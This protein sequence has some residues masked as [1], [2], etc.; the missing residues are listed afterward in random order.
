M[1]PGI[2]KDPDGAHSMTAWIHRIDTIVP[3]FS[4]LQAAASAKMQEWAPDERTRRII[5]ALYRQSGI[6]KR[7]SVVT[8]FGVEGPDGFF[9]PGPD[10]SRTSPGTAERND[11]F[12]RESRRLSSALARNLVDACPGVGPADI[13]HI[14]TASCT[15]FYN[16]GPD[17]HIVRDLGIP[18]SAERYHLGF[19]GC[20]AAF[21]ALRMAAQF[22][23][24]DP[25]A[26]VLVMCLE[27]CSLHLQLKPEEDCL[28]ANSLFADGAGAAIVSGRQPPPGGLAYRVGD[29]H[30]ALVT[31]GEQDMAWRIGDHG[32]DIALSSYVP[33]LIGANIREFVEPSL[34]RG[35]ASLGDVGTWA[36]HPGGKAIIDQVQGSLGLTAEQVRASREVL[37]DYG[38]MSSATIFFV[39]RDILHRPSPAAGE[40]V[41]AMAFGPGLTVEMAL[42]EAVRTG[43]GAAS[44][45]IP[46]MAPEPI[47]RQGT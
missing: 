8:N 43:A 1:N 6:E 46:G 28:L 16:P 21:P 10:G 26:V 18:Q 42:L 2:R 22:C 32:F 12:V 33:K 41:C 24:A 39:L 14:I 36:V 9:R 29:F 15:G 4:F 5:R 40:T 13:T 37:R 47:V 20:Y 3:E 44:V 45:T 19:M 17:Y 34:A 7:H 27:L 11:L 31:S 25:D 23:E 38:N 35:G 30:S